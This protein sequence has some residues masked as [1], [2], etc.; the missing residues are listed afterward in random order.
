M[1]P[2]HQS[3][4][5]S[6]QSQGPPGLLNR[7]T[8]P[9]YRKQEVLWEIYTAPVCKMGPR[10]AESSEVVPRKI[11]LHPAILGRYPCTSLEMQVHL[12]LDR[13]PPIPEN[14][15]GVS[16]VFNQPSVAQSQCVYS[17]A[18]PM[19]WCLLAQLTSELLNYP[20]T[21][22]QN[23]GWEPKVVV[24]RDGVG[25]SAATSFNVVKKRERE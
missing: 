21:L 16:S 23:L 6:T 18:S 9:S 19:A 17:P 25:M 20:Q 15:K 3:T 2:F 22:P 4:L 12:K 13:N 11:K 10:V 1:E 14:S 8:C 7:N 24:W 5:L